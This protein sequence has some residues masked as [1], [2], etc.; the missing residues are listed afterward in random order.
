[1]S[2]CAFVFIKPHAVTEKVKELVSSTL[3]GKGFTIKA[4]GSLASEEIDSK[5]LIDQ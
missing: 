4:E 1:M 3:T 2:N 5:K